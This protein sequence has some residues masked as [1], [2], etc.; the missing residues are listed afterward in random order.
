M[1]EAV[2]KKEEREEEHILRE[3]KSQQSRLEDS[4]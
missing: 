1:R 4:A 3:N 2:K